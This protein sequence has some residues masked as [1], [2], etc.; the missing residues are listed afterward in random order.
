MEDK[1][2]EELFAQHEKRTEHTM[3]IAVA[4]LGV[5]FL[6]VLYFLIYG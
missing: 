1:F 2:D 6:F 5:V 4:I 3:K